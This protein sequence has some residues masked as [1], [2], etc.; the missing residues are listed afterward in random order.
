MD[1]LRQE[2]LTAL[3]VISGT[4]MDGIDVSIVTSD[5]L[6]AVS[7]GA[8]ASYPYRD[9]TRA[10]LQ[11]LIAQ[12]ERALTEPL[13][14][15]EAEVTADHLAAIRRFIAEHEIDPAGIDL[16]GLHG[17]TV[18]H[19]PQQRFTRQLIDGPAIAAALG[20][21]TVDRFRHA[22]VAAGGEGAPFAPLY[23]RA[24]AQGMEQPV[25]VL[26]LGGVGNVTWI[27]GEEVIA[28]DTGPASALLDD[29]V[30][31]RLG[32]P[33]DA[34]G[35]LAASGRIHEDLVAAFMDNP[36]FDRPAPKSLDRNEF[37]RRAQIVEPLSDADGAATLAAF[38]V[39]SLVAALRHVPRAPRRWLVGGGGRLNRH[40]MQRLSSRLG[41]PVEP[42][43]AAGWDGDALE[44]QLFAYL[45]I[46]SV[47][48]LPLS[49]P[50]TTG[51]PWP[52]T[53]GRLNRA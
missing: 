10:A 8:G 26:N 12:A 30:L 1:R 21:A 51:V 53:G 25:M 48:G 41:V 35:A 33:Y 9:G 29:F 3:G 32:R 52:L 5:G 46:R 36:F 23:H 37:H 47:K 50:G 2:S 20:I 28:F 17:Q 31:R 24:L 19:R 22:D 27:E 45:A 49:L 18:Y 40:L 43:E 11:A 6:D 44:A 4:S 16:V 15:L 34:D 13:H 38:T 42:V 39:E 14:E 7:F